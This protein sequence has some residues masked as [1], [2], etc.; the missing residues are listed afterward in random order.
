MSARANAVEGSRFELNRTYEPYSDDPHYVEAN[1]SFVNAL[2]LEEGDR[3]LDLAC[4]IGT[5]SRLALSM[6]AGL[7]VVGLDL[8]HDGL[9]VAKR[10]FASDYQ[11]A[12][13]EAPVLFL[14][15]TADEIPLAD[16]SMDAV[17][18]G[19]SIHML[20]DERKLLREI[21][22]VSR[23][24]A[25][26]AFNTSFYAGTF[27]PGT[28]TIYH[29]WTMAA[30]SFIR[31]RDR[32]L[33]ARGEPGVRRTKGKAPAAFS[34][35]WL[36]EEEWKERLGEAGFEVARVHIRTVPLTMRSFEAIG[37]YAGF[38][39]VLLSGYPLELASEALQVAA[40]PTFDAARVEEVPRHWLEIL[41]TRA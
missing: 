24:G 34:R 41:S 19:H 2:G 16:E 14:T 8:S 4:G 11:A 1:R 32:Q 22:R 30:L 26:F 6:N 5:L 20:P 36:S 25:L 31:E 39:Q 37:A 35:P 18:M 33:R 23:P 12:G 38:V 17:V 40:K 15:A 9:R 3:V 7:T 13:A 29:D 28:E 21:H 27:A 10:R